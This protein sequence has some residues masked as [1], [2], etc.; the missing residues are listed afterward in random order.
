MGTP[1]HTTEQR[2]QVYRG[3]LLIPGSKHFDIPD[4]V[5]REQP[6]VN[7]E[8]FYL[9]WQEAM[10][11]FLQDNQD[12][13]SNA[14]LHNRSF[15]ETLTRG[16]GYLGIE[17]PGNLKLAQL[18]ELVL[19]SAEYEGQ[20][21]KQGLLFKLHQ[22]FPKIAGHRKPKQTGTTETPDTQTESQ[23]SPKRGILRRLFWGVVS[24]INRLL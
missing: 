2:I 20:P 1:I 16:L 3:Y 5:V 7:Y 18:E 15:R 22:D 4:L 21:G 10:A 23:S 14:W 19:Q 9:C 12:T 6:L 24:F 11:H 13:F 8:Q 17:Q